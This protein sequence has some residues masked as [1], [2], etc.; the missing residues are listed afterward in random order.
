M[1][2]VYTEFDLKAPAEDVDSAHGDDVALALAVDLTCKFDPE[3]TEEQTV[4]CLLAQNVSESALS[5]LPEIDWGQLAESSLEKDVKEIKEYYAQH[6]AKKKK[7][8]EQ[9]KLQKGY[10]GDCWVRSSGYVGPRPKTKPKP[11]TESALKAA[12]GRLY[13]KLDK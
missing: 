11:P 12:S 9:I 10:I 5:D 13:D 8:L 7:A 3:V 6:A 1:R 2:E 4:E